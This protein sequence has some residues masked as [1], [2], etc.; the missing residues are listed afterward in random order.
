MYDKNSN[1]ITTATT[2]TRLMMFVLFVGCVRECVSMY[3]NLCIFFFA[4]FFP[5]YTVLQFSIPFC[6]RLHIFFRNRIIYI[7]I[8]FCFI[9][10]FVC[11]HV[12]FIR[13]TC[14]RKNGLYAGLFLRRKNSTRENKFKF[15]K[16]Y[17]V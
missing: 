2:T 11:P 3:F 6:V 14:S 5:I 7:L 8:I 13:S 17:D 16:K 9:L 12:T 1:I 15:T 10:S 4:A